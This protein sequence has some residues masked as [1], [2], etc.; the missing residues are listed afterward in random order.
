MNEGTT[1]NLK[2]C[3]IIAMIQTFRITILYEGTS[4]NLK[5]MHI[6]CYD[7]DISNNNFVATFT[8]TQVTGVDR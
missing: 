1:P 6:N 5:K 3:T 2:K 7:I 4:S 8:G